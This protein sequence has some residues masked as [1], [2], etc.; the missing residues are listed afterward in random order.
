MREIRASPTQAAEAPTPSTSPKLE[1]WPPSMATD[2]Q[3]FLSPAPTNSIKAPNKEKAVLPPIIVDHD[4][5]PLHGGAWSQR[6]ADVH[7]E[8][9]AHQHHPQ[10]FMVEAPIMTPHHRMEQNVI[11]A[12]RFLLWTTLSFVAVW[13]GESRACDVARA[14]RAPVSMD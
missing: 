8:G 9:D 2:H 12:S 1:D 4:Y 7:T 6:P 5:D 13:T 11:K 10:P 14:I 3:G